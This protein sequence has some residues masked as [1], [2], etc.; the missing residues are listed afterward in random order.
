MWSRHF[1]FL[2]KEKASMAVLRSSRKTRP[3][4][5]IETHVIDGS[6]SQIFYRVTSFPTATWSPHRPSHCQTL[7]FC[8][9]I[10]KFVGPLSR[11]P[12]T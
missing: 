1:S 5:K 10:Q 2:F 9:C 7:C 3:S 4:L 8:F 12:F 6:L 11:G